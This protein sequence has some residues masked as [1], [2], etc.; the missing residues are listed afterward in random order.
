MTAIGEHMRP[1]FDR[2]RSSYVECLCSW[3]GLL[4]MT[5]ATPTVQAHNDPAASGGELEC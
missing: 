4:S 3:T 5:D 1:V 2:N